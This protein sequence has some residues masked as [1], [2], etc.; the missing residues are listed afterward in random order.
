MLMLKTRLRALTG[1]A[2]IFCLL[3]PLFSCKWGLQESEAK[4]EN[5]SGS[6]REQQDYTGLDSKSFSAQDAVTNKIYTVNAVRLAENESCIVYGERDANISVA[7]AEVIAKRVK[8]HIEPLMKEVFGDFRQ[9]LKIREFIT[10]DK[11]VL[12]LLDIKDSYEPKK[13]PSYIA[14]YFHAK[15]LN[16]RQ[17]SSDSNLTPMIY[18]DVNPGEPEKEDGE[19]FNTIAHELQHLINY[20]IRIVKANL[21]DSY[22]A[23]QET[24]I[25]EG[26]A[27][28]AEYL[29]N[30]Q[31]VQDK[32]KYFNSDS[33]NVF[34]RGN[35]FLTWDS[36]YI[37]YCT[38][39]LFFQ[40]LRI[41]ADKVSG[42]SAN[43]A[44]K[45]WEIYQDIINSD[46]RDYR[47]VTEAARNHFN[48]AEFA[49]WE[50]LLSRWLLAN[51]VNASDGFLGYYK[52][53]VT[54]VRTIVGITN[55][56]LAPGGGVFSYL[57]GGFD[58]PP[59]SPS[60]AHIR[61]IRVSENGIPNPSTDFFGKGWLLTFNANTQSLSLGN[62]T[63]TAWA[64][65]VR[66]VSETGYLTGGM[67]WTSSLDI[68]RTTE[69]PQGPFPIDI[70]PAFL[71]E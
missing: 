25:D 9:N 6:N 3:L 42:G 24:W 48:D 47:A 22:A 41:Q 35:N 53:I 4:S 29:Y 55:I 12:L 20:S 7:T 27:S 30:G 13:N 43:P 52:E 65:R 57:N 54:Q 19:F 44:Y 16:S 61:Y 63:P 46:Y 28:A 40:W 36:E 59:Y 50:T 45:G 14:G 67:P 66:N 10:S 2:I 33:G 60:S 58:V 8:D 18:M 34:A 69:A 32:I 21:T 5:P 68:P 26:L 37:D 11:L 39:Y 23:L 49:N 17:V 38:I 56:S 62:E 70:P 51:H 1:P 15:D 64:E 31:H 71:V